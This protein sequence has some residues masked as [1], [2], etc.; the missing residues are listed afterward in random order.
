MR[1]K[2]FFVAL[3]LFFISGCATTPNTNIYVDKSET[4]DRDYDTTWKALVKIVHEKDFQISQIEKE[5]GIIQ[6]NTVFLSRS[7]LDAETQLKK[8]SQLHSSFLMVWEAA[9]ITISF[10]VESK[11]DQKTIVTINPI[12]EGFEKNISG[13]W[14]HF[15]SNGYIENNIFDELDNKLKDL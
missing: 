1:H 9:R 5:S 7:F 12:I 4:F 13:S 14:H 15:E 6:T 2:H 8:I 10:Y 11:G 3:F